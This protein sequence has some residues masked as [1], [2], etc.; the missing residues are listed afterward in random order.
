MCVSHRRDHDCRGGAWRSV[1]V[2][3]IITK[4][5]KFGLLPTSGSRSTQRNRSTA[6]CL[7]GQQSSIFDDMA[8]R[9]DKTASSGTPAAKN[10]PAAAVAAAA[11]SCWTPTGGRAIIL[12]KPT[13][14]FPKWHLE[15][16]YDKRE[17]STKKEARVSVTSLHMDYP[18]KPGF[19]GCYHQKSWTTEAAAR[20]A[21]DHF[22]EWVD[23]GRRKRTAAATAVSNA[24]AAVEAIPLPN[25]YS[26]RRN[27]GTCIGATVS[28]VKAGARV[29]VMLY[30]CLCL[31]ARR[32]HTGVHTEMTSRTR[33]QTLRSWSRFT[34]AIAVQRCLIRSSAMLRHEWLSAGA[35]KLC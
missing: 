34:R 3:E 33:T 18:G 19:M 17:S 29:L 11:P 16:R 31:R 12:H 27:V 23:G 4:K 6:V 14:S 35:V 8:S 22:R 7:V 15:A 30:T 20:A 25:R 10:S 24:S 13:K 2:W 28:T 32:V 26:K 21:M 1:S 5:C 9:S